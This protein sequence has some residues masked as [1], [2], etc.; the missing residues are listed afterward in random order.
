MTSKAVRMLIPILGLMSRT[1]ESLAQQIQQAE[2]L[3]DDTELPVAR[4]AVYFELLGTTIAYSF[5]YERYVERIGIRVGIEPLRGPAVPILVNYRFEKD[6]MEVG[7]G[8]I[9][10]P[11][12]HFPYA[13]IDAQE[14]SMLW[15]SALG[16]RYQPE[17]GGLVFRA[18]LTL[19][20]EKMTFR[21]A[22][23][24]PSAAPSTE[25]PGSIPV[26]PWLGFSVGYAF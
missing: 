18:T 12:R 9:W 21:D 16:Y 22:A 11:H 14:K 6:R 13:T 17:E 26:V 19:L 3:R 10:L 1:P 25:G 5:N 24:I 20:F 2:K 23:V 8:V 4:N 7:A 15:T